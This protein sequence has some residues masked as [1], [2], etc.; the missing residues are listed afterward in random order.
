MNILFIGDI[1]GKLGRNVVSYMINRLTGRRPIDFII[2][3]GENATHG[4][5]INEEHFKELLESGI[6]VVTLGNHFASKKEIFNFI[7]RYDCLLRPY[8]VHESVPG[9]GTNLFAVNGIRIRVT[10]LMGRSFMA[11]QVG[12]PFDDLQKI[13]IEDEEKADI[14]IV[15]FHAEATGEKYAL[16]Y[17]FDGQI[18]ALLGTHTHVQ[19]RDYRILEKGT[20]YISDVGMCGPYNSILGTRK[21]EVITRTWTGLPSH[22]DMIDHDECLFSA[23]I[24]E[25]DDTNFECLSI[26]PLYEIIGEEEL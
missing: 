10:N 12:N 23:V 5:G 21:E 9:I 11:M 26:E 3:N 20:A 2:A 7:D 22:F 16:A 15:D 4:K 17:A 19:T 6:D 8:N 25:F 14:H 1:V 18:S 24:L 13:L